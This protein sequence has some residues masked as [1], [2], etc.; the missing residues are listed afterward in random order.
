MWK[1]PGWHVID[2]IPDKQFLE[3]TSGR[4]ENYTAYPPNSKNGWDAHWIK[5]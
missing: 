4:F 2:A 1:E 3:I 5:L